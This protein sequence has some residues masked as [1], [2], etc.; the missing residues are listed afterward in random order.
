MV[1]QNPQLGNGIGQPRVPLP[2]SHPEARKDLGAQVTQRGYGGSTAGQ[3]EAAP[4]SSL[5]HRE[6]GEKEK[7]VCV[8]PL[9]GA[10]ARRSEEA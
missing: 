7:G 10:E 6:L 1:A 2:T 4:G 8:S 9:M 5:L 3:A